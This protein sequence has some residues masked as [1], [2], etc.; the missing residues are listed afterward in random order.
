MERIM[1]LEN[2][3]ALITGA[4]RNIGAEIARTF[5]RE[6]ADL[7]L[8]TRQS[9]AELESVAAEC[10][11]LGVRTHTVIGDVSDP[12]RVEHMVAEGIDA[13]GKV[14]VLVS[15]VA[16]RPHK[17]VL[18]VSVEE[19]QDVIATNLHGAFYLIRGVLPGMIERNSGSII[20]LGGQAAITGRPETAVVTTAKHGLLGLIRSIAAECAQYGVRA[21]L[22]NPGSTDTS[23]AHPEWYPEFED[24][25]RGSDE[26]LKD[27]PLHRQAT[28]QDIA[29]A[30]LFYASDESSYI[31]GDRMNVVGGR[32][33]V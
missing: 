1:R 24:V 33:I 18:E 2:K 9:V 20:G 12:Q 14:D 29:N 22:V 7:I 32:Y 30:C 19:W 11:E 17:P 23:R 3:T 27:I 28:V 15:N 16:V 21:N 8:N 13:L 10:R 26:H 6:G 5:A 4:S 25:A 31:T